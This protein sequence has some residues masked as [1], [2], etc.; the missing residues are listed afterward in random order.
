[1]LSDRAW[2]T[3]I[4]LVAAVWG[5]N[6]VIA[7]IPGSGYKPEPEIHGI[8]TLVLTGAFAARSKSGDHRK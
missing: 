6:M 7:M 8:F 3:I 1:M 5:A 2:S 4:Y